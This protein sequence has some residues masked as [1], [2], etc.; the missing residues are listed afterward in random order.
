MTEF[1]DLKPLMKILGHKFKDGDL[2]VEALTH[3]SLSKGRGKQMSSVDYERLEFLGD[4]I[5]G[6]IIAE[7]LHQRY[8]QA[9]A[10]QLSRR[11]NAQVRKE[12]LAEIA[13]EIELAPY[14]RMS[15]ELRLSGGEN[16][17]SLLEDCV[18][19]IIAALYLDG[20]MTAA[21]RFIKDHW[22]PRFDQKTAAHKD[23]KSALQEW[24]AKHG[25]ELPVYKIAVQ[26]G[27]DHNR[28]FTIEV[29]LDG[30]DTQSARARSKREAEKL[31]AEKM[32]K[33]HANG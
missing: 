8:K 23:P 10:G 27:P 31:A 1:K 14:I 26:E 24:A 15:R 16:S 19:A 7:E 21:K 33:E 9:E 25:K 18:E 6:L 32:L 17:Q 12:T 29:T 28:M 3:T 13:C 5:L 2:L 11:F 30:C 20:G 22:W 4:R